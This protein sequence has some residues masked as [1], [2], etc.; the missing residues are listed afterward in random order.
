EFL[1][2]AIGCHPCVGERRELLELQ[3]AVH[4]DQIASRDGDELR[5]SAIGPEPWPTNVWADM[6]VAD[7]AM[8]GGAISPSGG[9]NDVVALLK[10]RRL[11]YNPADLAHDAGDF[12]AQRNRSRNVSV[13]PEITVHELYVGAAHSACL[14]VDENFIGLKAR[15]SHVF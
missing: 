13:F 5:E 9:D 10:T 4:L 8:T 14:D 15:N 2:A 6:R 1:H 11:R 12:M 3:A 7:L